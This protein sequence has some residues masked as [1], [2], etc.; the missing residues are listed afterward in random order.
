MRHV[1]LLGFI[2][3]LSGCASST[4]NNYTQ[5]VS[6]WRGGN[7]SALTARWGAPDDQVTGPNGTVAYLYN[8]QSY[9]AAPNRN[10]PNVGVHYTGRSAPVITNTNPAIMNGAARGSMSLNCTAIFV[11]NRQGQI[12]DT[13]VQGMGCYG[14]TGFA[15]RMGNPSRP[16]TQP[17]SGGQS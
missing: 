14:G 2:A 3:L 6:S 9:R 13:Q 12:I 15:T 16:V 7:A 1:M 10:S 5:T 4:N 17:T 11:A 8:T